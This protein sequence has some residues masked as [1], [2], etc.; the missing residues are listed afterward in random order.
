MTKKLLGLAL[1]PFLATGV[2]AAT[3]TAYSSLADGIVSI[4]SDTGTV[5]TIGGDYTATLTTALSGMAYDSSGVL[6][7]IAGSPFANVSIG[8]I[9][10]ATGDYTLI[11]TDNVGSLS[12]AAFGPDDTLYS[13]DGRSPHDVVASISKT[14]AVPA[15]VGSFG[16]AA[17]VGFAMTP[18]GLFGYSVNVFTDELL[19]YDF[20]LDTTTTIGVTSAGISALAFAGSTLYATT[21]TG[22][23]SLISLD[24]GTGA[25]LTRVALSSGIFTNIRAL[26]AVP[27]SAPAIPVPAAGLLLL[28]A[29]GGLC[30]R[31]R[32]QAPR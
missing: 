22:T 6:W 20:T 19:R 15:Y 2:Q 25:E 8:T 32:G 26:A 28:S 18:D 21:D 10:P 11:G 23:D 27:A 9:D 29:L 5:T 1:L 7:G 13:R 16:V 12:G 31:R 30:I 4:D 3:F 24:A 17:T 14:D